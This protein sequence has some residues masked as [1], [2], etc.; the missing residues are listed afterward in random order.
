MLRQRCAV[1]VGRR[2]VAGSVRIG[3]SHASEEQENQKRLGRNIKWHKQDSIAFNYDDSAF[4]RVNC[5]TL[6]HVYRRSTTAIRAKSTANGNTQW[7]KVSVV[8]IRRIS[9][10]R[11]VT[12]FV[13]NNQHCCFPLS[14]R[15]FFQC[16]CLC[17][18]LPKWHSFDYFLVFLALRT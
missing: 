3:W 5:R 4:W 8:Y 17:A 11:S 7:W 10:L 1:M 13:V 15:S 18:A 6:R 14:F 12:L 2:A 16:L 9:H